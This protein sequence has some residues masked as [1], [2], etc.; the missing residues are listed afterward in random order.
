MW[1]NALAK[2]AAR[3]I[4]QCIFAHSTNR[5]NG[6]N[7]YVTTGSLS[8]EAVVRSWHDEVKD[9]DYYCNSCKPGKVCGHYTQVGY[10]IITIYLVYC[11]YCWQVVWDKTTKVGCAVEHCPTVHNLGWQNAY[12]V[13]CTYNPPYV[14]FNTNIPHTVRH[15]IT[16]Y[17]K[18]NYL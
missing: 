15:T 5:K 3:H 8:Y 11:I 14:N 16:A 13:M 17:H 18:R 2:E 9:Y 1:N 10:P 7:I 4:S 6:E 12:L